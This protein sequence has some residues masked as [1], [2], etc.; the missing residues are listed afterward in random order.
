MIRC[1][2]NREITSLVCVQVAGIASSTKRFIRNHPSLGPSPEFLP[3]LSNKDR[4]ER[5]K[6]FK[7]FQNAE[8]TPSNRAQFLPSEQLPRKKNQI[9]AKRDSNEA[10]KSERTPLDNIKNKA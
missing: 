5:E 4:V 6:A 1:F 7:A 10:Q 9:E 2:L 3:F 8:I